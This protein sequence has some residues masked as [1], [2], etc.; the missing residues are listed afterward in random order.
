MNILKYLILAIAAILLFVLVFWVSVFWPRVENYQVVEYDPNFLVTSEPNIVPISFN[1]TEYCVAFFQGAENEIIC[2]RTYEEWLDA[3]YEI[4]AS[5]KPTG[6]VT[7]KFKEPEEPSEPNESLWRM[8][9][10]P[11]CGNLTLYPNQD[12]FQDQFREYC[13]D[14][15]WIPIDMEEWWSYSATTFA[16][17]LL[18]KRVEALEQKQLAISAEPNEPEC[19]HT[20]LNKNYS[21]AVY[22]S[23][24]SICWVCSDCGEFVNSKEKL[25]FP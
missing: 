4:V 25:P 13:P 21:C 15:N 3:L 2:D 7:I 24:G 5:E 17:L 18:E 12:A 10:N 6:P 16:T 14:V 23:D 20:N 19:S 1:V 9:L 11:E 8:E 22:H